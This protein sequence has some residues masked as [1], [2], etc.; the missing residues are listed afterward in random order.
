MS[1]VDPDG[2]EVDR[3]RLA[4]LLR[5]DP[6]ARAY[7]LEYMNVHAQ[8]EKAHA[9]SLSMPDDLFDDGGWDT[10]Q[11]GHEQPRAPKQRPRRQD[12]PKWYSRLGF[13]SGAAVAACAAGLLF[14][15]STWFENDGDLRQAALPKH[16]V[17]ETH[18]AARVV[19][20]T[21]CKWKGNPLTVNDYVL[22]G[23]SV[24]LD[25]GVAE[26]QLADGA[27]VLLEGPTSFVVETS[28]TAYLKS[29][30]I[31]CSVLSHLDGF[32]V[33]TPLATIVN[34]GAEFGVTVNPDG[35]TEAHVTEGMVGFQP[36]K[37]DDAAEVLMLS[38]AEGAT[39][40]KTSELK[41]Q[42]VQFRPTKAGRYA[43]IETILKAHPSSGLVRS[44]DQGMLF[45]GY[46]GPTATGTR[47]IGTSTYEIPERFDES[48]P[49]G[50]A[51]VLL[52]RLPE[53]ADPRS[54]SEVQLEFTYTDLLGN[55]GYC[56]DLY[57]LGYFNLRSP[58]RDWYYAGARDPKGAV[59]YGMH[60]A[61]PV[62]LLSDELLTPDSEPGRVMFGGETMLK[63]FRSLYRNGAQAGDVVVF[64]LSPNQSLEGEE[65]ATGYRVVHPP[66]IPESTSEQDLPV[67]RILTSVRDLGVAS[68]RPSLP[69]PSP[70]PKH[71]SLMEHNLAY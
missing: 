36:N 15:I 31:T 33:R 13:L 71:I 55:P 17:Y 63:F 10:P 41:P 5:S 53:V 48:G 25:H 22:P 7:Y 58:R 67:L 40:R 60:G 23:R 42:L 65:A 45:G 2:D 38:K 46:R 12:S 11:T 35:T 26:L 29:G 32:T 28:D 37:D 14:A 69:K 59:D 34:L 47:R 9:L 27:T 57:G 64:R 24:D 19:R 16:A 30:H 66:A 1:V 51:N 70:Q 68:P 20:L 44:H 52:F 54:I 18:N 3:A 43:E 50:L 4:E 6:E 39:L 62:E 21:E 49:I 61:A 8:L 56:V